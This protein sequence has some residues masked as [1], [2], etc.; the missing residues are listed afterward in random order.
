MRLGWPSTR[1]R[2]PATSFSSG[3]PV[4]SYI[5]VCA[6]VVGANSSMPPN[7]TS[8]E[9][10]GLTVKTLSYHLDPG[11]RHYDFPPRPTQ[12]FYIVS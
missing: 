7:H 5:P 6:V 3:A 9:S 8:S 2:Y 12:R 11:K 10:E 1:V 4:P